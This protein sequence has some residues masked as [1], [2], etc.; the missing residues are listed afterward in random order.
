MVPGEDVLLQKVREAG[1]GW[2]QI[3]VLGAPLVCWPGASPKSSFCT[4]FMCPELLLL[5]LFGS[6]LENCKYVCLGRKEECV[7]CCLNF[8]ANIAS[9]LCLEWE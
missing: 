5:F 2:I 1:S 7:C 6:Q 3:L 8:D 4:L 9:W